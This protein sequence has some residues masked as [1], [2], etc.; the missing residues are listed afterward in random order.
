MLMFAEHLAAEG[1]GHEIALIR[2]RQRSRASDA[3]SERCGTPGEFDTKFSPMPEKPGKTAFLAQ[4][5][6]VPQVPIAGCIWPGLSR[7][8]MR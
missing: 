4:S 1:Q 5:L 8:M 7:H 6:D 2:P 3:G